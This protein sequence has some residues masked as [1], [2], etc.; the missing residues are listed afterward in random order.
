MRRVRLYRLGILLW[1]VALS[2]LPNFV[3]AEDSSI[4]I[5]EVQV[6]GE[7]S[8]DEF[9][10]LYNTTSHPVSIDGWQLRR[11]TASGSVSSIKVFSKDTVIQPHS[12]YLWANSKG[13]FATLADTTTSSSPLADNNSIALYTESGSDGILIDS[14]SWGSGVT[15]TDTTVRMNQPN[16][17]ESF[18]QLTKGIW[19]KTKP[20]TPMNSRAVLADVD[21]PPPPVPFE[22]PITPPKP[23]VP[24]NTEIIINEILA[25]PLPSE[26]EFIELFNTGKEDVTLDDWS[27]HDASKT[28]KYVFPKD[29]ILNSHAFLI[30]PKSIFRFALNN[31]NES[32]TL[33]D[34]EGRTVQTATYKKS[35]LGVSLNHS[36]SGLRGGTPTPG[37]ENILNSLPTTRERVPKEGFVDIKTLFN[38]RGKDTEDTKLKYTWDFGDGHKSY[39][40]KTSH[41]YEKTGTYTV[42]LATK[43][44]Q[45]ETIETF[46]IKIKN[47]T[48]P[49]LRIV[50]FL[51]NP[52]GTDTGNEWVEIQNKSKHDVDL[53]G[54]SLASGTKKKKLVNHPI[55][56]SLV[57]PRGKSFRLTREHSLFTLPNT[58]GYIEL[59]APNKEAID[60]ARYKEEKSIKENILYQKVK[61][62]GWKQVESEVSQETGAD[63]DSSTESPKDTESVESSTPEASKTEEVPR[64]EETKAALYT[65]LEAFL[66]PTDFVSYQVVDT[67]TT[68]KESSPDPKQ[69]DSFE[70][71]REKINLSL[72]KLFLT[73]ID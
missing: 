33:K 63:T 49:K 48:P 28:G 8:D 19:T 66:V 11:K 32:L 52:D 68:S 71:F 40:E 44:S 38:A 21:T 55:K 15:F 1:S 3:S 39:L 45:D 53:Q 18:S 70:S 64:T 37:Q 10:E 26:E 58:Q 34:T 30:I 54:F 2:T 14:I 6:S 24:Q 43:D 9:I 41:A 69:K 22:T 73:P 67:S 25:N 56:E 13:I 51:P 29:T 59:R 62:S 57:I 42:T 65:K 46:R 61:G 17:N 12:Y 35:I 27:L 16:K 31:S 7:Q 72:A 36:S 4:I 20:S 60:T 47:Y 23:T 5:N 50:A